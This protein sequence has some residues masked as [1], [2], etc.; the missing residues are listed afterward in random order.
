MTLPSVIPNE[1]LK[2]VNKQIQT[3]MS[4]YWQKTWRRCQI[5]LKDID[6]RV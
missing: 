3:L 1:A 5:Q 2:Q 6:K 4:K